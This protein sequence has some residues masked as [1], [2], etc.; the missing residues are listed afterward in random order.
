[1]IELKSRILAVTRRKHGLKGNIIRIQGLEVDLDKR[2]VFFNSIEIL[3]TK[4][5]YDIFS[6]LIFK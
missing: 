4:K 2:K 6:F 1:M 3:L 5:E